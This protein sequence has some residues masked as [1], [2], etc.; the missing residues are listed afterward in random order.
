MHGIRRAE[1]TLGESVVVLGLG[2]VGQLALSL[3]HLG[4]AL[5][6]VAIDLDVVRLA[7]AR[8][9][10]A[11]LSL[12]AGATEE[13]VAQVRAACPEDGAQVVIEATGKPA[14]YPLAVRLACTAGRVVGLGSPRGTV[15]MDFMRDVHLREVDIVGAIQP[16]TPEQDHIYYRWSKDRDRRL[17]LELMAMGRLRASDLITHRA[18][19]EDCQAVYEM[20]AHRPQ[21]ALGVVFRWR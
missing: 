9:R 7:H 15:E 11:D 18:R 1:L 2:M 3:A 20:L 5:P 21:E 12:L 14:A 10:G 6:L 16:I 8:R 13:V 17:L 4:G 19:P